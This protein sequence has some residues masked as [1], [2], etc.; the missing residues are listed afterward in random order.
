M[1]V[2]R[3][4][5][6]SHLHYCTDVSQG[7]Q[8]GRIA[9]RPGL[10]HRGLPSRKEKPANQLLPRNAVFL[11]VWAAPLRDGLGPWGDLQIKRASG[12]QQKQPVPAP[13]AKQ[14][15]G[16]GAHAVRLRVF[17]VIVYLL[18]RLEKHSAPPGPRPS[19]RHSVHLAL[20]R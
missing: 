9:H 1:G 7:P 11:R 6:F 10:S 5:G 19:N 12:G 20:L 15:R 17:A 18:R 4:G 8:K 3:Y 13:Y 16:V 14:G 2:Q